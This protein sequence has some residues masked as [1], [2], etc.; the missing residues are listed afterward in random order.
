MLVLYNISMS[1]FNYKTLA[2]RI[3]QIKT[4]QFDL[5]PLVVRLREAL[6]LLNEELSNSSFLSPNQFL[7]LHDKSSHTDMRLE[8]ERLV[9][10]YRLIYMIGF[11]YSVLT[12]AN[13]S[14]PLDLTNIDKAKISFT[15][16]DSLNRDERIVFLLRYR[17]KDFRATTRWM[18]ENQTFLNVARE[19]EAEKEVVL[20]EVERYFMGQS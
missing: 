3:A 19:I 1:D 2:E 14:D 17:F 7:S 4:R 18:R 20:A 13:E 10:H 5:T 12:Y 6:K 15:S 16:F 8:G 9:A 11:L